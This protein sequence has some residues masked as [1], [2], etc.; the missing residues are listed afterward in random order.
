MGGKYAILCFAFKTEM[1]EGSEFSSGV[2]EKCDS[3][4]RRFL[5][6]GV[7]ISFITRMFLLS[8]LLFC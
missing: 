2:S 8:Y 1:M 7:R 6:D 5:L 4:K 3:E